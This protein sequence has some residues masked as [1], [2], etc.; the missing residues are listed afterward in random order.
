[1]NENKIKDDIYSYVSKL[2]LSDEEL[3]VVDSYVKE[4]LKYLVPLAET[5]E[6]ILKDDKEFKTF[7]QKI[8]QHLGD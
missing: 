8:L 4:L 7:K 1:M 6:K 5:Q 2:N 3:K